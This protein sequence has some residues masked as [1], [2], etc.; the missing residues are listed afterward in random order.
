VE[1]VG[2]KQSIHVDVRIVAATHRDLAGM[3]RQGGFREDLWYRLAVFPI[4]IPPLRERPEDIGPLACHF[5][6]KAATRFA[7]AGDARAMICVFA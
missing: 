4:A 5:A 3:V 7:P 6:E 1:R 2:G